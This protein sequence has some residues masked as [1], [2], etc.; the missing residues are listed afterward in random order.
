MWIYL[1]FILTFLLFVACVTSVG[2]V[3]GRDFGT[4]SVGKGIAALSSPSEAASPSL[5]SDLEAGVL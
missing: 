3:I 5:V 1:V 4:H 2:C